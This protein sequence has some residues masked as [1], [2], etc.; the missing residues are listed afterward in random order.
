M[1]MPL[2]Q[3]LPLLLAELDRKQPKPGDWSFGWDRVA[4]I[5]A[6]AV[7]IVAIAWLVLRLVAKRE[8]GAAHSPWCLFRELCK[9]HRLSSRERQL[10]IRLAKQ[11]RLEQPAM[12]FIEPAIWQ[13]ERLGAAWRRSMP[14]L[15]RLRKRLFAAR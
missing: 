6:G 12:L 15:D 14:E 11:E 5:A 10:L 1:N 3:L 8:R 2:L 7:V 4:I 9:A 13:P